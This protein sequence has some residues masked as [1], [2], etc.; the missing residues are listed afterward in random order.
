MRAICLILATSALLGCNQSPPSAA[1]RVEPSEP[2][3]PEPSKSVLGLELGQDANLPECV[4]ERMYG[5]IYYA[6]FST[7]IC[8]KDQSA[9]GSKSVKPREMPKEG[10]LEAMFPRESVPKGINTLANIVVIGGKIEQVDLDT[11]N[12]ADQAEISTLLTSK[13]GAPNRTNV[14][15]L[16]NGFGARFSSLQEQWNFSDFSIVHIGVVT[17]EGGLISF[18]SRVAFDAEQKR[19]REQSAQGF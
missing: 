12:T 1:P 6:T 19:Q 18:Q 7:N 16:Q 15:E 5:S 13:W 4:K 14:S 10:K 3:R 9:S 2:A 8:W 17:H 11:F